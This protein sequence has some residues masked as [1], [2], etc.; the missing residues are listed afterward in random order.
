[1]A[2][3]LLLIAG[4]AGSQTLR[5]GLDYASAATI[6]DTCIAWATERDMRMAIFVLEPHGMPVTLAHMD[7]TSAGVHDVAR[8]KANSAAHSGRATADTATF[9][10]PLNTPNVATMGGGV[11]IYTADGALLGG[12]GV[13]G[14]KPADDIACATAGIAAAGLKV[15]KPAAPAQ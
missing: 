15:A 1:M 14:G 13:S 11:P 4:T 2:M 9:N 12:V 5:P 6:R 3:P 8:W 7:G 10:P